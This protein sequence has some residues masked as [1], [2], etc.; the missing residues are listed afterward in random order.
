MA[1]WPPA[2]VL[3]RLAGLDRPAVPGLRWSGRESW[4]VTLRFLGPLSQAGV[5]CVRAALAGVDAAPARAVLG[6]AVGRLSPRILHVPVAG[7]D[8][9]AAAVVG[10]TAGLGRPPDHRPFTGHLTLARVAK[11]ADVALGALTGAPLAA[12]WDV[13]SICLAQSHLSPTGARYDVLDRFPLAPA[14]R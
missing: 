10:A 14:N 12:A 6:P 1:V 11:G 13:D 5:D 9:V 8:R 3:D 4:H 2:H 7:L